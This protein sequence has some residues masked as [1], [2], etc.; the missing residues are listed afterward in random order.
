MN[1]KSTKEVLIAAKWIIKNI[2][3]S[4]YGGRSI[5]KN[6]KKIYCTLIAITNVEAT[7]DLKYEAQNILRGIVKDQLSTWND[8]PNR[9]KQDVIDLFNK[10]I[11]LAI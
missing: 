6:G 4:H 7:F 5:D 10:G 11:K 3:W 1:A 9:T 2:G 8:N